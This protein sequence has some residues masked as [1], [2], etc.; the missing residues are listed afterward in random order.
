MRT[1][2]FAVRG[3]F[4]W[5]VQRSLDCFNKQR[6]T[7]DQRWLARAITHSRCVAFLTIL[8]VIGTFRIAAVPKTTAA[9][10]LTQA[11]TPPHEEACPW[12]TGLEIAH[13]PERYV[14]DA[15]FL[16]GD[17]RPSLIECISKIPGRTEQLRLPIVYLE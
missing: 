16:E 9:E 1:I 5:V 15:L 8:A 2:L 7:E 11:T 3:F 12:P 14:C 10:S 6:L 17:D 13:L 4:G